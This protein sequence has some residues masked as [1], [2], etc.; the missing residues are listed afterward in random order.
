MKKKKSTVL[1][2][3]DDSSVLESSAMILNENNYN[4]ILCK[5][6]VEAES[7]MSAGGIDVILSDIKM[8]EVS[9]LEFL[10][11]VHSAN[12]RLPVI[13]MTA[14]A[15]L[16]T[17]IEAIKKGAFDF[18][19][20]PCHPDY[21]NHSLQR[22]VQYNSF[23]KLK[24]QYKLYLEDMV[25]RRIRDLIKA[26][27]AAEGLGRDIVERLT[28]VAEFR[29]TEAGVH[30]KRMGIF[31][32]LIAEYIGMPTDFI[33]KLNR[34]SPLHDI[35]KIGISDYILFKLGPLTPEEYE[36]IKTHTTQ[37]QMIL[38]GSSHAELKMAESLALNHHERWDG[39]GYPRGLK[40]EDIPIE[41]RIVMIVDQ[42]DALRS[43]RS[44]KPAFD[45]EKVFRIITGGDARTMPSH[46]DPEILNAFIQ[47]AP[48]FEEVF[49]E[50]NYQ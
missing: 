48:K 40:G 10:E 8:P 35:G 41:G 31:T 49:S 28:T 24:E 15:D 5:N 22:A 16:N 21:L 26:R 11:K 44:Y 27:Q 25:D 37:G 33:D 6:A 13:L 3:D 14:Y 12:P 2:V 43:E 23:L 46:F 20:K 19:I 18:I 1:L 4:V 9:G 30:V 36:V 32:E 7:R 45:H 42:Y 38:K 39:T 17:T 34:A 47:M 50:L 29:N